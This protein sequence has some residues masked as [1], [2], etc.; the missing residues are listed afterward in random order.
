MIHYLDDFLIF[1]PPGAQVPMRQVVE[2][3]FRSINLSIAH[4]KTKGASISLTFLGIFIDACKFE[5]SLPLDKVERPLG[6]LD[7]EI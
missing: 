7:M 6:L 1:T 5:L 4:H 2:S 3:V